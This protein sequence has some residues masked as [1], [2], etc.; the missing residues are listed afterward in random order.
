MHWPITT[1]DAAMCFDG[2]KAPRRPI[3]PCSWRR[4]IFRAPADTCGRSFAVTNITDRDSRRSVL[5]DSSHRGFQALSQRVTLRVRR[6]ARDTHLL[7]YSD[8][9]PG[10]GQWHLEAVPAFRAEF[11]I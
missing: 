9:A 8:P 6:F 3:T 2:T 1:P 10:E 7:A 11:P 4:W 5:R